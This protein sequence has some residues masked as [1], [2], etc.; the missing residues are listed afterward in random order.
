MSY[1]R[2]PDDILLGA[3]VS[4]AGGL[5]KAIER[6]VEIGATA[7]Q[8]FTKQA[9]R[10]AERAC[11]EEEVKAWLKE[12]LAGY[13]VPSVVAFHDTLPREDTGKIFKRRLREPYWAGTNRRI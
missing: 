1:D 7:I 3:H 4:T 11:E 6:A 10:W 5:P 9:T 12:R 13:K 2:V 8:V